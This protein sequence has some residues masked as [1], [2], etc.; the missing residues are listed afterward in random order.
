MIEQTS[1]AFGLPGRIQDPNS[2]P[3]AIALIGLGE[4]GGAIV[5]SLPRD[6]MGALH[7]QVFDSPKPLPEEALATIK[8]DGDDLHRALKNADMI[9]VVATQGDDVGLVPV[10][11][12]IARQRN[13]QVTAIYVVPQAA[14]G[15][16]DP[17]LKTLRADVHM[18]VI[19]SDEGYVAAMLA[20]LGS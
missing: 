16:D 9:F 17:H 6:A 7:V 5:R 12:R 4:G 10:V 19:A 15:P 3:R 18:L 2:K 14:L 20:A 13:V 11:N 1:P 8:S